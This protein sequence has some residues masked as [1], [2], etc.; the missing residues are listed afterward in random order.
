VSAESK[1]KAL[2]ND[3]AK[4]LPR[5]ENSFMYAPD[6]PRIGVE[7]NEENLDRFITPGKKPTSVSK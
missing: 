1:E 4:N 7:L 6:S 5:Y 3:L 2:K